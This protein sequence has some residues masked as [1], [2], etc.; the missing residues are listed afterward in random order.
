MERPN[1]VKRFLNRLA[2]FFAFRE[3]PK[4]L[5]DFVW[6]RHP[7]EP[8]QIET[9]VQVPAAMPQ[10]TRPLSVRERAQFRRLRLELLSDESWLVS[11]QQSETG[12][13]IQPVEHD[14]EA[15]LQVPAISK[16]LH[17]KARP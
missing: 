16:W 8:Q 13:I 9:N 5:E 4:Q 10:K 15:T 1:R 3:T 11:S 12:P 17:A 2:I 6:V 14:T 7:Y